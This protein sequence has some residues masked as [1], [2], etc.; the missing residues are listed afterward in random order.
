MTGVL[1]SRS[2]HINQSVFGVLSDSG[3][4]ISAFLNEKWKFSGSRSYNWRDERPTFLFYIDTVLQDAIKSSPHTT[5]MKFQNATLLNH[6]RY[7]ASRWVFGFEQDAED[8]SIDPKS[9]VDVNPGLAKGTE[10]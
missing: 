6:Q 4:F 9:I 5:L 8:G 1:E 7:L 10:G 3:N 2:D